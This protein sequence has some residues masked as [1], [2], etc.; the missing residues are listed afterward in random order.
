[1]AVIELKIRFLLLREIRRSQ[2]PVLPPRRRVSKKSEVDVKQKIIS[3]A[4]ACATVAAAPAAHAQPQAA[5]EVGGG[6]EAVYSVVGR[7]ND[8]FVFCTQGVPSDGWIAVDPLAGTYKIIRKY[9]DLKWI[10]Q[11]Q[12][13]CPAAI[14]IGAWLGGGSPD[15]VPFKH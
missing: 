14:S 9:P 12:T 4:I 5:F 11:Y 1:M 2:G 8:P 13:V 3:T 15:S 7:S 10:P 6:A